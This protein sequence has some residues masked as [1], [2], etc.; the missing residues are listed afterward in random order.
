LCEYIIITKLD[1]NKV[2]YDNC[3]N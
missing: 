3:T 1:L 2:H